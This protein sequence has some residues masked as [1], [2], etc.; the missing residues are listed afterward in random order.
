[1]SKLYIIPTPIG[2]LEDITLRA[3]RVLKE[4]DCI[5]A[6]D[7]RTT[8]NLLHHLGINK[9]MYAHHIHN[10]HKTVDFIAQMIYSGQNVG[11][12]TDAGTPGISDPGYL[13]IRHCIQKEISIECLPGPTALIPALI[14]SGLPTDRFI[15]EGFLPV[16]KGRQKRLQALAQEQ[17]T[18]ILY[19]SPHK[20]IKTLE[21]LIEFFGEERKISVS[22]ELTKIYEETQRNTIAQVLS[23]FKE[24]N[25]IKGEFVLVIEGKKD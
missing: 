16:K 7:T 9:R 4:V 8:G 10:E 12:V 25:N 14:N 15:F 6:E 20:L 2:N 1:M 18:I 24:K 13:L 19:E 11:L 3:I 17:R 21:N 5:V 22:R 23:Y